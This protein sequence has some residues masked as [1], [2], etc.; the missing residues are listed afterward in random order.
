MRAWNGKRERE[1]AEPSDGKG[2]PGSLLLYCNQEEESSSV[3]SD[4]RMSVARI[5][6][7]GI[8]DQRLGVLEPMDADGSLTE[9]LA[10]QSPGLRATI[11]LCTELA[12]EVRGLCVCVCR[13]MDGVF[14]V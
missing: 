12:L 3:P 11:R 13:W 2:T 1:R 10:H 5:I 8:E 6:P 14:G 7:D 9:R 4:D